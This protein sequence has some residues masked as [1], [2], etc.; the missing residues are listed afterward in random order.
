MQTVVLLAGIGI[1]SS[2]LLASCPDY[3][4]EMAAF[5]WAGTWE[6]WERWRQWRPVIRC[7]RLVQLEP[8]GF[9]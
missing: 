9:A 7:G 2:D 8:V 1:R 5:A 3:R 6:T 4:A